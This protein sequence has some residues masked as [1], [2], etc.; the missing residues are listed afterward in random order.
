MMTAVDV[1]S[2]VIVVLVVAYL[3]AT[4]IWPEKF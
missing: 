4:L 3:I 1:T 2:L